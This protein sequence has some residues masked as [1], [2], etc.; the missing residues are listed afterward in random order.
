MPQAV[1]LAG[2]FLEIDYP[3]L[4]LRADKLPLWNTL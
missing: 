4:L 3:R 1:G 2:L